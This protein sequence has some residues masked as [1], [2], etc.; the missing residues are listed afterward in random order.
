M[1]VY[2]SVQQ[3]LY[4]ATVRI[5]VM[6]GP[7]P[8]SK[9]ELGWLQKGPRAKQGP[10]YSAEQHSIAPSC[11]NQGLF[12]VCERQIKGEWNR[13]TEGKQLCTFLWMLTVLLAELT[14]IG[15]FRCYLRPYELVSRRIMICLELIRKFRVTN[16]VQF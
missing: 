2:P 9:A 8:R 10:V 4:H 11:E 16:I 7:Y 12:S 6:T 5:K 1:F 3:S 15:I 13:E 14:L